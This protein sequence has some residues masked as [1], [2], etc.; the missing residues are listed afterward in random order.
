MNKD[1]D[2]YIYTTGSVIKWE[3]G[4]LLNG[5]GH[6]QSDLKEMGRPAKGTS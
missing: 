6:I 4:V 2:K 1:T 3:G 5:E